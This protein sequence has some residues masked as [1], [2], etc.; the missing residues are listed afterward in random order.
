MSENLN[1][2]NEDYIISLIRHF[3]KKWLVYFL[4]VATALL[5]AFVYLRFSQKDYIIKSRILISEVKENNKTSQSE[6]LEDYSLTSSPNSVENA[7]NSL[8]ARI[9]VDSTVKKMGLFIRFFGIGNFIDREIE[10]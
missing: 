2:L 8:T 10:P 7:I 1:G 3:R 4:G 6:V 5:F 9:I